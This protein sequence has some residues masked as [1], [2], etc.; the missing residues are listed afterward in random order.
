MLYF[1]CA[2]TMYH[3]NVPPS[4]STSL[5]VV[6][7]ARLVLASP[8]ARDLCAISHISIHIIERMDYLSSLQVQ[9]VLLLAC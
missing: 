3:P 6:R 8:M 2:G 9:I 5:R 1:S 7:T 4:C